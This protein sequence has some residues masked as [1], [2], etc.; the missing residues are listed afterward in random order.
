MARDII[1]RGQSTAM[2]MDELTAAIHERI[3]AMPAQLAAGARFILDHPD[4]VVTSSMRDI[5]M[6]IGVAPAT[7]V[8][9]ARALG[10][11]DWSSLREIYVASYRGTPGLYARGASALVEGVGEENLL[12]RITS[13]LAADTTRL[14]L[15]NDA[16]TFDATV[17][18]LAEAPRIYVAAFL[19]CRA[20]G[21]TFT[22]ISRLFR[23]EVHLSG[24]SGSSLVTELATLNEKDVVLSINF[25]PYSRDSL[26]VA[27][28]VKRS[29]AGLISLADSHVTPLTYVAEHVLLFETA[30]PSFF[31]T[32]V[33]ATALVEALTAG[34]MRHLGVRAAEHLT[35]VE[36]SLYAADTYVAANA[37]SRDPGSDPTPKSRPPTGNQ[38]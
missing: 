10:F 14:G 12:G 24:A 22:Y 26:L 1:D 32:I 31:P 8:R 4:M 27:G 19:S 2:L 37:R 5:A 20:P 9:L 17:R 13:T 38:S 15:I 35:R 28:A 34:M 3:T 7:L 23:D 29:G 33:A 16:A 30:S 11:P 18:R 25:S 6:S 21:L 36:E